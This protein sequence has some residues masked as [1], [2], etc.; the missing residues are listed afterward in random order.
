[1]YWLVL[2]KAV[3]GRLLSSG[4]FQVE[5][6]R[7]SETLVLYRQ[8][9]FQFYSDGLNNRFKVLAEQYWLP[10]VKQALHPEESLVCVDIGANI[11]EVSRIFRDFLNAKQIIAIEPDAKEFE[12]LKA[13]TE[14]FAQLFNVALWNKEAKMTFYSKNSTGDSSLFK[15][16]G[17]AVVSR[18]N[19]MPLDLLLA[20]LHID[21]IHLIKLEAEG[22]EPEI[23]EGSPETLSRTH[24]ISADLGPE[25]GENCGETFVPV[26]R[27]LTN[28]GFELILERSTGRRVFLF[29]NKRLS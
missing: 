18:V 2:R 10:Q 24:F 14:D 16:P 25:R 15:P 29:E 8:E 23:V 19:T 27:L 9:R 6:R 22:A 26:K 28:L 21:K 7:T 5:D 12:C 4:L 1:M 13:N 17:D 20:P 11:G 3:R